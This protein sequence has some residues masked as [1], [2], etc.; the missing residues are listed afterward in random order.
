MNYDFNLVLSYWQPLRD[1]LWLT[2]QLTVLCATLGRHWVFAWPDAGFP[3]Q[4]AT[5]VQ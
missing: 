1:G 3:N 4:T 2:L 5:P